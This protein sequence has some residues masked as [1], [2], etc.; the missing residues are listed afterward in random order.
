[1][2]QRQPIVGGAS[3]FTTV[4][5]LCGTSAESAGT[6]DLGTTAYRDGIGFEKTLGSTPGDEIP[7]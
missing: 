4:D 5:A 3:S 1:L 2:A 6:H 7:V